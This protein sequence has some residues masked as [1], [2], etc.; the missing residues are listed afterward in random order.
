MSR[1]SFPGCETF[2]GA[3]AEDLFR[4]GICLPSSSSLSAEEQERV[5]DGVRAACGVAAC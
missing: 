2:G 3:V 1:L 5:V 4:R